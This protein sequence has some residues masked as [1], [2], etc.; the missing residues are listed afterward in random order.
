M[1]RTE[2]VRWKEMDPQQIGNRI[3]LIVFSCFFAVWYGVNSAVVVG[4]LLSFILACLGICFPKRRMLLAA[5]GLYFVLSLRVPVFVLFYPI[6]LYEILFSLQ[7]ERLRQP[8]TVILVLMGVWLVLHLQMFAPSFF[9]GEIAVAVMGVWL[10]VNSSRLERLQ[11]QY[12]Q[13]QDNSTE[14]T[15]ELKRE[16]R[17]LLEKQDSEVY[18]A[19]LQ[20]RNRI[21]REIHDNVGHLLSR[22]I[23]MT[24]ALM[25]VAKEEPVRKGLYDL[26]D[27]LDEAMTSIRQSVHDLH[28]E[29]VDLEQTIRNILHNL[30]NFQV[31]LEYD[32]SEQLPGEVKYCLIAIVKEGV[33]NIIKHSQG[34]GI[35]V[36]MLEHPAFYKL[37]IQ[38]N[39]ACDRKNM[40]N[41]IGL[42]NIQERVEHL[43]GTLHI[44]AD[45]NGFQVH[46]SIPK[47]V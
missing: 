40:G 38:D 22:G 19:T 26:K 18:A 33:S 7:R 29:S 23:L 39:G 25:T 6:L 34:D 9:L 3:V 41:G 28:D 1:K 8:A 37:S 16:K 30:Q 14:L 10:F 43:S 17:Y 5:I 12:F 35:R 27:C 2:E 32:M 47:T 20:E 13:V 4:F 15:R 11:E 31:E 21:A 24:G 44:S 42:Y 45:K 46:V 36:Q